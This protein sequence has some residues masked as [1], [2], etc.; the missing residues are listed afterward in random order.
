MMTPL[1][2]TVQSHS[3]WGCSPVQFQDVCAIMIISKRVS[4]TNCVLTPIN[5]CKMFWYVLDTPW[6]C[7][8]QL[9]PRGGSG[10]GRHCLPRQIKR[11][12][13]GFQTWLSKGAYVI[14]LNVFNK[15]VLNLVNWFCMKN[16]DCYG[17]LQSVLGQE[18]CSTI[19]GL[20]PPWKRWANHLTL[21]ICHG[22]KALFFKYRNQDVFG[23]SLYLC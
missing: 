3:I 20:W 6:G 18:R 5:F 10:N 17:H 4:V 16:R 9:V 7:T 13:V 22:R 19:S 1:K 21:L 14:C 15:S 11:L 23:F 8:V 12:L 2:D